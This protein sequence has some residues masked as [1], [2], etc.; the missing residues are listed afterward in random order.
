MPEDNDSVEMFGMSISNVTFEEVCARIAHRVARHDPGFIVTPNV[1]H[2]C[3]N[4]RDEIFREAYRNAFLALPD[5]KPVMWASWLF[6][7]PLQQ[8]L[9]GSDMVPRLTRFAAERGY[10]VYFL[11]GSAGTAERAAEIL[12]R[13]N[14]GLRVAGC[15]FPPFG[16]EKDPEASRAAID[17]VR[18]ARPDICF[19]AL[20]SPK[21]ELWMNDC[22]RL[23]DVPVS[24]GV[25]ASFD[26]ISGRIRRAPRWLQEA[27]FEW[28][29]RLAM[30]PRR[31]WRRYLIQDSV[32]LKLL[33]QEY[34]AQRRRRA[35][36][37]TVT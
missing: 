5:G 6:G 31:L 25:G 33:W 7:V 21:Q 36:R 35:A 29:W 14:P 8:K 24:I 27:G 22:H 32:F 11:G 19:V 13:D 12:A 16:F 34:F 23:C 4:H 28:L 15:H 1:N 26:F 30:E 17:A 10:S 18:D 20:G 37:G 3:L 2:V 9:S